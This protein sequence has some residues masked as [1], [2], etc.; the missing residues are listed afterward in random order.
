MLKG[1][2][3]DAFTLLLW[4]NLRSVI[5]NGRSKSRNGGSESRNG[6][7]ESRNVRSESRNGD[8]CSFN[9]TFI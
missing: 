9:K 4:I 7:S 3:F 2:K 6:G 5:R 8:F 1:K